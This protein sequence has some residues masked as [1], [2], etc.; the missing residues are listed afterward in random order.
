MYFT[1]QPSQPHLLSPPSLLSGKHL[2]VLQDPAK[3]SPSL[4]N[5]PNSLRHH[6]SLLHALQPE[7]LVSFIIHLITSS[8]SLYTS[9]PP[10]RGELLQGK[11]CLIHASSLAPH[12][13]LVMISCRC[14]M[15]AQWHRMFK[16]L[17][18]RYPA[19]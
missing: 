6:E 14:P 17:S 8:S 1:A 13:V 4:W 7:C 2:H 15:R 3:M 16:C 5:A 9:I 19:S 11:G 12:S 18:Q 10:T